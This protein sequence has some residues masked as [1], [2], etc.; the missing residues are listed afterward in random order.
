MPRHPSAVAV[1]RVD[2]AQTVLRPAMALRSH[3]SGDVPLADIPDVLSDPTGWIEHDTESADEAAAREWEE[4]DWKPARQRIYARG[5][6]AVM[7]IFE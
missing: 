2:G 6:V 1:D 3:R 4:P 5:V 7:L